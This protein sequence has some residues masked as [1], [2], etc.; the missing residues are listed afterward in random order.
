MSPEMWR[1]S[2]TSTS[3]RPA[4]NLT[5]ITCRAGLRREVDLVHAS[6]GLAEGPGATWPEP[7]GQ[8]NDPLTWSA[9]AK[10]CILQSRALHGTGPFEGRV[11]LEGCC[12]GMCYGLLQGA[13]EEFVDE[14]AKGPPVHS[15]EFQGVMWSSYQV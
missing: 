14:N 15:L 11:A 8:V 4:G 5:I 2:L 7:E 10:P 6:H 9:L 1:T 3:L 12:Q 13:R